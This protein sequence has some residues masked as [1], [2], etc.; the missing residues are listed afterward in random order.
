MEADKR[1][2]QV[3]ESVAW[4]AL[5]IWWGMSFIPHFLPNG[6]DAAGTGVILL[7]AN[8]AL[9]LKGMPVNGFA[10]TLGILTLAWGGLDLSRS[11]FNL[12]YRLP[13]FAILSMLLGVILLVSSLRKRAA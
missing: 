13:V 12:P 11:V 1:F 7:G 6:L 5:F 2:K 8:L 10:V 3:L 4:G 9:L